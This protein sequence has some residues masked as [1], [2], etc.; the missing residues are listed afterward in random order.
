M[1]KGLTPSNSTV[2]RQSRRKFIRTAAG[3]ALVGAAPAI[4]G[5][6]KAQRS[7]KTLKIL[8]WNHFVPGFDEWFN[9]KYIKA[10]GEKYGTE[11]IVDNVGMSSINSRAKAE[12]A[13]G[14]GHD[15]VLF[16]SP[17]P[18]FEQHAIDHREIW[19]ECQQRHGAPSELAL[20]STY[21]PKTDR[22]YGFSDSFTP[23]PINY[24]RDLWDDVGVF[25]DTW[26][27][28]RTGGRKVFERHRVPVGLGLAPELDSNMA[29]RSLLSAFGASVQNADGVPSLKSRETLA[30]VEFSNALYREAMTDEVFTWDP[31]SN[32]R[33]LLA[34]RGS[35]A[36]NAISITR[37][38]ENKRIPVSD[39]IWLAKAAEGPAGR[40]G[41]QHLVNVYV[42]WKFAENIEGA[43][44]F[45]IDYTGEFRRAFVASEFYNFPSFPNTVPDLP[46]LI[47]RD[48][49]AKPADK[50]NVFVDV[51]KWTTNVG[52]PGYANAATD[53]IFT[54]WTI[55]NMFAQAAAGRMS[56]QD[57]VN[58]ADSEVKRV[59]A[60]WRAAGLV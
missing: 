47:E 9:N 38:G 26:D 20:K 42:V 36:L 23:D 52:H 19:E 6:A 5:T 34:G 2:T 48:S 39:R 44:Q 50:Y 16:L 33:L 43:K 54:N 21:N 4:I 37:T 46:A 27:D 28:I 17:P 14:R 31:S 55:S 25:P 40:V 15:M 1:R 56:P 3:T 59:F 18:S 58:A 41:L 13:A 57:A 8:Q 45:L 24:R 10:W 51:A 11:V 30:A 22:Y 12:V 35:L 29:L 53:E 7:R 60:K 49:K 32:N